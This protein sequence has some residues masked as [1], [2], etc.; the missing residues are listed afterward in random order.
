[1]VDGTDG[2]ELLVTREAFEQGPREGSGHCQTVFGRRIA[3][4]SVAARPSGYYQPC[5]VLKP[6]A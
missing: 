4:G 2:W 3:A 6:L 1:M 5:E